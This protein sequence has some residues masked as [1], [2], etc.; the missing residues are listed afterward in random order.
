MKHS[1]IILFLIFILTGCSAKEPE[2][3]D[4]VMLMG[5]SKND[6]YDLTVGISKLGD[7]KDKLSIYKSKGE[8]LNNA[9][10]NLNN[11]T[12]GALF[13]GDL[14]GIII[15]SNIENE[16]VKL[17][18]NNMEI[19]RDIP[20]LYCGNIDDLM[21]FENE[22]ISLQNYITQYYSNYK[23]KKVNIETYINNC[24]NYRKIGTIKLSDNNYTI[25]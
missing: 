18:N 6:G 12:S 2:N 4:F 23:N 7:E 22:K 20:I 15:D 17:I 8:T 1:F 19:G 14:Q 16:I 5:I 9:L 11:I 21:S 25:E 3:R 13:L 24:E 10:Y